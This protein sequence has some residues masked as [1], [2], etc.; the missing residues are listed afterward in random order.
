MPGSFDGRLSAV[1]A[2]AN[3][4]A[5][6]AVVEL[7]L[8]HIGIA[9]YSPRTH[10]NIQTMLT[11]TPKRRLANVTWTSNQTP[12]KTQRKAAGCWTHGKDTALPAAGR[13]VGKHVR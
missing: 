5:Q 6:P 9:S 10:T 3:A 13:K 4:D 11:Q 8:A 7:R 2:T 1:A 12:T